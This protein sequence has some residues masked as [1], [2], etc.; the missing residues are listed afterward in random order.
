M[1]YELQATIVV[2]LIF[3]AVYL[4]VRWVLRPRTSA[5]RTPRGTST[6]SRGRVRHR[7]GDDDPILVMDDLPPPNR[8]RD[9]RRPDDDG[10]AGDPVLVHM[11]AARFGEARPTPGRTRADDDDDRRGGWSGGDTDSSSDGGDGGD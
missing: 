5:T 9:E 8:R 11:A 6:L 3:L 4:F 10:D 7:S 2:G 1:P